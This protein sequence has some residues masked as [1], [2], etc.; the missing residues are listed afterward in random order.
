MCQMKLREGD[1]QLGKGKEEHVVFLHQVVSF[2]FI[3]VGFYLE[4]VAT[5][6]AEPI[7]IFQIEGAP[8]SV[9]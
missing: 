4:L 9:V 8:V 1:L 2:C 7:E 3:L 5:L 6:E